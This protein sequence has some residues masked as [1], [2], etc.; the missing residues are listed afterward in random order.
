MSSAQRQIKIAGVSIVH[1]RAGGSQ[2]IW[3]WSRPLCR[4]AAA[5]LGQ[6]RDCG[7]IRLIGHRVFLPEILYY[8]E[9]TV[10]SGNGWFTMPVK[11]L[12]GG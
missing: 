3:Q 7:A 5:L 11:G 4:I 1:N 10:H 6:A 8:Q 9:S 12:F 2:L